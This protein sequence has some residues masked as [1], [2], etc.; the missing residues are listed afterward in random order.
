MVTDLEKAIDRML[1][2]AGDFTTIVTRGLRPQYI[3][4]RGMVDHPAL[5]FNRALTA[6]ER[7]IICGDP[8]HEAFHD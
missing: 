7:A 5:F 3:E 1:D 4:G 8:R 6:R 2:E